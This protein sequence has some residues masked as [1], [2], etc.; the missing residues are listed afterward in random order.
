MLA[1]YASVFSYP[2]TYLYIGYRSLTTE[3]LKAS[4]SSFYIDAYQDRPTRAY[5]ETKVYKHELL[6]K[7]LTLK[8]HFKGTYN[9]MKMIIFPKNL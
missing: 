5:T 3:L 8:F 2:M 6:E 4:V 9:S 7:C 1:L